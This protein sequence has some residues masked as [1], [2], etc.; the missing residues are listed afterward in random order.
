MSNATAILLSRENKF[1]GA[2]EYGMAISPESFIVVPKGVSHYSV[3]SAQ[4]LLGM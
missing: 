4:M 3:K 2:M 1:P